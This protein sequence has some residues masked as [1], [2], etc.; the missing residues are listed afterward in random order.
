M[1]QAV[2]LLP[3]LSFS[4]RRLV[5]SDLLP[6]YIQ[7]LQIPLHSFLDPATQLHRAP[8]RVKLLLS[9]FWLNQ[10]HLCVVKHTYQCS[11]WFHCRKHS[12]CHTSSRSHPPYSHIVPF[13]TH[14]RSRTRSDL[15]DTKMSSALRLQ[16]SR[17]RAQEHFKG[18][19]I[20]Q[21]SGS[22]LKNG[23]LTWSWCA[24][25]YHLILQKKHN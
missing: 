23:N 16:K 8:L 2:C 14:P 17:V 20:G 12:R 18:K 7:F 9:Q 10:V 25:N 24:K 5:H 22:N 6:T 4:K 3:E 21:S 15:K 1:A 11:F 13:H 19:D